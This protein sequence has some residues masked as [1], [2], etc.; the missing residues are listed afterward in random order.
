MSP[1]NNNNDDDIEEIVS[2]ESNHRNA[3]FFVTTSSLGDIH[4]INFGRNEDTE[5]NQVNIEADETTVFLF[6]EPSD[7]STLASPSTPSMNSSF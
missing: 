1:I 4:E 2:D 5:D 3:A 6:V 7:Q